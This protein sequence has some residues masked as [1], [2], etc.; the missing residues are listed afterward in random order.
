MK[1][2]SKYR[3]RSPVFVI[4]GIAVNVR[5]ISV[6]IHVS[7]R[8]S[9]QPTRANA[10]GLEMKTPIPLLHFFC[11]YFFCECERRG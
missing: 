8:P 4:G 11:S 3:N 2:Y 7:V 10:C 6:N 9:F 1:T 5:S